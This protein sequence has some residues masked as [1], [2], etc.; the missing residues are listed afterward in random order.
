MPV[1]RFV[2]EGRDVECY[3]GENLREVALRE[4]L[5]LYG[6]KGQLGNCGGCGQCITCF[7]DVVA[8]ASPGALTPRTA[9]EDRK[10]RR[11]PEGWRLACQALVQRS[12]VV[13]T[14]P[15]AGLSDREAR[16]A[17]ARAEPLP[18]GPTAWP[19]A[20]EPAAAEPTGMES[21]ATAGEAA[22]E[23]PVGG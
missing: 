20:E 18:A 8:E 4:G 21:T 6:L 12:L 3:P 11:R 5:E 1:I 7:V 16:L 23:G 13:L 15:Q 17:A 10:L 22:E 19:A 14:R 9:V 2:R